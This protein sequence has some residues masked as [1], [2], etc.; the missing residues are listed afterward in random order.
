MVQ[1][2]LVAFAARATL[3]GQVAPELLRAKPTPASVQQTEQFERDK[4][5]GKALLAAGKYEEAARKLAPLAKR[6]PDDIELNYWLAQSY[7]LNGDLTQAEKATQ[8]L[9]DLRPD[10]SGGLW[11]AALLREQFKDLSGAVDLLNSVYHRTPASNNT[12]R[13]AILE[14]LARIFTKQENKKDADIV[15][16]EIAR[17]KGTLKH[18]ASH[19]DP[20]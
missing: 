9:L 20:L 6:M 1:S 2:A 7:R 3:R 13:I 4:L 10:F 5:A 17:L 15:T 19:S 18:E 12:S 14:D 8:W 16:G 11:E